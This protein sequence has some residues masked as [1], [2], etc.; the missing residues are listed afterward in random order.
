LNAARND[1]S[2]DDGDVDFAEIFGKN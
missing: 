2:D 1:E